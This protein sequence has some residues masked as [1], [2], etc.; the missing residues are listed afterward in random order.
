MLSDD[1]CGISCDEDG[2]L[3]VLP[4]IPRSKLWAD[5]AAT[6]GIDTAGLEP[7]YSKQDKYAVPLAG[8]FATKPL[9]LSRVY[10]LAPHDG[11]GLSIEP[12]YGLDR[13]GALLE[14]TFREPFLTGLRQRE[15]HLRL[16]AAVAETADFFVV[17]RVRAAS[18]PYEVADAIEGTWEVSE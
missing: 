15:A 6:L 8:G 14:Q 16:A 18:S 17:G 13:V 1:V 4:G 5:A 10:L 12:L 11:E 7:I 9:A 2:N 3:L